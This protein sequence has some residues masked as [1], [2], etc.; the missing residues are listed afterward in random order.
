MRPY[1]LTQKKLIALT[2]VA[3]QVMGTFMDAFEMD[4]NIEVNSRTAC[5]G[6]I[7]HNEYNI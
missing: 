3:Q 6:T 2:A 7:K 4:S 1:S 5:L